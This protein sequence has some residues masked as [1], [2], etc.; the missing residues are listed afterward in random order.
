MAK[1]FVKLSEVT[2][3]EEVTDNASV[4]VEMDGEIYR[5]PKTQVGGAGIKTAIIR[6][7]GY[8]NAIAGVSTM[9]GLP[10]YTYECLNMTFEEAYET[11]ANGEPLAVMGML[12]LDYTPLNIYGGVMF[13]GKMINDTPCIGVEFSGVM[14][15]SPVTAARLYWTANGLSTEQPSQ[16]K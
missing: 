16:P 9:V 1:D 8:L 10:A 13:V 2:M 4:L 12:T 3:L 7:S 11:M 14:N 6:D 15:G 5:A